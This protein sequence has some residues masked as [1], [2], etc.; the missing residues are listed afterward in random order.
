MLRGFPCSV[1]TTE[2]SAIQ[3]G[4]QMGSSGLVFNEWVAQVAAKA[5]TGLNGGRT[6]PILDQHKGTQ[7]GLLV[8]APP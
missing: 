5:V 4:E 1:G 8:E 2:I 7:A 6:E 3:G